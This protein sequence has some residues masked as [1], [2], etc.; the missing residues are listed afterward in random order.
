MTRVMV[1]DDNKVWG[2]L[3]VDYL[4]E[5]GWHAEC[6]DRLRSV[7]EVR[8]WRPDVMLLDVQMPVLRGDDLLRA[9]RNCPQLRDTPVIMLTGAAQLDTDI[10]EMCQAWLTKPVDL[11]VLSRRIHDVMEQRDTV[12]SPQPDSPLWEK[13]SQRRW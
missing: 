9:M 3:L 11:R 5:Q 12:W 4:Q 7:A 1:V 13:H 2:D 6:F 10:V 8:A